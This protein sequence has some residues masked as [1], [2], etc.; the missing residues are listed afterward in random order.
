MGPLAIAG[1]RLWTFASAANAPAQQAA[2]QRDLVALVPKGQSQPP[3]VAEQEADAWTQHVPAA[4]RKAVAQVLPGWTVLDGQADAK[5]GIQAQWQGEKN[6]LVTLASDGRPMYLARR[7]AVPGG[8][9]RLLVRVGH[10]APN[11]GKL[12]V[13]IGGKTVWEQPIG[14]ATAA[15]WKSWEADLSAYAGQTVCVVV[16]QIGDGKSEMYTRWGR[17]EVVR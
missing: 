9:P 15:G 1:D 8:K 7:L 12:Q 3:A 13:E 4:L 5:T 10:D 11:K 14:Q 16:S 17:L 6:V 2:I